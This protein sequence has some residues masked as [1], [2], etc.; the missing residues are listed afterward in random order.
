MKKIICLLLLIVVSCETPNDDFIV[1]SLVDGDLIGYDNISSTNTEILYRSGNSVIAYSAVENNGHHDSGL[2]LIKYDTQEEYFSNNLRVN[3]A[4]ANYK[5]GVFNSIEEN[6]QL[7]KTNFTYKEVKAVADMTEK[8]LRD[9]TE[10]ISVE[11]YNTELI[12]SAF[13]QLSVL[14]TASRSFETNEKCQCAPLP[15]YLVGVTAFWCQEDYKINPED[16]H[17]YFSEN[18]EKILPYRNGDLVFNYI[19]ESFKNRTPIIYSSLFNIRYDVQEYKKV[20]LNSSLSNQLRP[21]VSRDD[22]WLGILGS[23]H[24]CCGNYSGC[25]WIATFEC[26]MHDLECL[27]CDGCHCGPACQPG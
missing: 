9:L 18:K 10:L 8:F 26:F 4:K 1:Q 17:Y 20:A 24:G 16:L 15:T 3:T 13:Y 27:S 7:V 22:C 11:N 5:L 19:E 6:A 12:Q 2:E 23:D 14:K 21:N 25:C